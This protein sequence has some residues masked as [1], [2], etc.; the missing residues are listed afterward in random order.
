MASNNIYHEDH[1][2]NS[3]DNDNDETEQIDDQ[4]TVTTK[5][6]RKKKKKN[7]VQTVIND[8]NI[9]NDIIING[10]EAIATL[11]ISHDGI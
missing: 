1:I 3:E 10:T 5:K 6:K 2:D 11:S 9:E 4:I 7:K 8:E